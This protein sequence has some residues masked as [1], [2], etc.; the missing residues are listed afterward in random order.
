MSLEGESE[1]LEFLKI[2]ISGTKAGLPSTRDS[3]HKGH[4]T[5][6]PQPLFPPSILSLRSLHSGAGA[7]WK[8]LR[9]TENPAVTQRSQV[10]M[11]LAMSS[12][13]NPILRRDT[14]PQSTESL[15]EV[16]GLVGS[17]TQRLLIQCFPLL[18]TILQPP[19]MA[20]SLSTRSC[21]AYVRLRCYRAHQLPTAP[22]GGR[23]E[24]GTLQD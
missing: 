5:S 23:T 21:T 18:L 11:A 7:A 1:A 2:G 10:G 15:S 12:S 22:I 6:F 19:G 24:L 20:M 3:S 14:E 17:K 13:N 9:K 8:D 4:Q 16:P